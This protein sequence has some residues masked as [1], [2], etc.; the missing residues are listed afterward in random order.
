M[1]KHFARWSMCTSFARSIKQNGGGESN[2]NNTWYFKMIKFHC[3]CVDWNISDFIDLTEIPPQLT[4]ADVPLTKIGAGTD[5]SEFKETV[6]LLSIKPF[7]RANKCKLETCPNDAEG[8]TYC[9]TE[10]R[11]KFNNQKRSAKSA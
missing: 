3:M 10:C 2:V 11:V 6:P 5:L 9:S 1:D 8:K 4:T 7:S